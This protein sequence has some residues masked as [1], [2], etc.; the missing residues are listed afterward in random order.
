MT[1][2][3]GMPKPVDFTPLLTNSASQKILQSKIPGTQITLKFSWP[4]AL[5][6]AQHQTQS[7]KRGPVS[8]KVREKKAFSSYKSTLVGDQSSKEISRGNDQ[9]KVPETV[10]NDA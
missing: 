10:R 7:F 6:L 2:I 3:S 9:I 1:D 8:M 4:H 5:S